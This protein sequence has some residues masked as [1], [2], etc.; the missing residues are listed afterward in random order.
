MSVLM[1]VIIVKCIYENADLKKFT[2]GVVG[3]GEKPKSPQY[4]C[5]L[6]KII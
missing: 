6:S 4:L 3:T 2:A 5:G 1:S